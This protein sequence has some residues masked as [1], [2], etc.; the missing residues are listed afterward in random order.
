MSDTSSTLRCRACGGELGSHF[1][2]TG[3]GFSYHH[4][5]FPSSPKEDEAASLRAQ[6]TSLQKELAER[7]AELKKSNRQALDNGMEL[8]RQRS[9]AEAA[10]ARADTLARRVEGLEAE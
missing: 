4:E 10:E 8:C 7:T 9:R 6:I 2:W 1:L 5:C 3:D